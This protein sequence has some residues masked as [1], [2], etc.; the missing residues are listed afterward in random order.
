MNDKQKKPVDKKEKDQKEKGLGWAEGMAKERP[1]DSKGWSEGMAKE[2]IKDDSIGWPE[3]QAKKR[4]E[5]SEGWAEGYLGTGGEAVD[6]ALLLAKDVIGNQIIS[7][8]NGRILGRVKD[9]YLDHEL[10]HVAGLY[11]GSEGLLSSTA[12]LID[13]SKIGV[14]S[15]DTVLVKHANVVETDDERGEAAEWLRRDELQGR[16][17]DTP[18]GTRIGKIGD[19]ILNQ[20]AELIGFALSHVHVEGPIAE[21]RV[22]PRTA[23]YDLGY[24]DGVM[25]INLEQAEQQQLKLV[26]GSLFTESAVAQTGDSG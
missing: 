18:G 5:D 8:T 22:L 20:R 17:V 21:K 23:V 26:R 11:L 24:E 19:V 9:I 2:E 1:D 3:G 15:R 6:P 25:T 13:R 4:E 12:R 7:V 10:L 14:I 16:L